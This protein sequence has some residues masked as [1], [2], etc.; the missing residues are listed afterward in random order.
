MSFYVDYDEMTELGFGI[1]SKI[2]GWT[3][4]LQDIQTPIQS[5][6]QMDS[7][8]GTAARSVKDYLTEIYGTILLKNM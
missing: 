5:F 2:A 3:E 4:Q 8:R 7:F 1:Q 6:I